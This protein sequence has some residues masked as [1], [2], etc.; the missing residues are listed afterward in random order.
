[1][2]LVDVRAY[3]RDRLDSLGYTEWTDGFN[4]ENIPSTILDRSYHVESGDISTTAS[5]HQ[6]HRFDC[7]VTVRLFIKGY[8]D[9]KSAIDDSYALCED[10]LAEVL[11]PTNRLD[12]ANGLSDVQPQGISVRPLT[13]QNDNG[14]V[15][16]INFLAITFLNF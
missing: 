10:I 5:N 3:F 14:V 7:P 11:L 1:M 15:L 12:T 4:V 6:P 8:L 16:E 13:L 9:P 2:G